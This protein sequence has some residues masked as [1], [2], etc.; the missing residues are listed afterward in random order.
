MNQDVYQ[1]VWL[2]FM[3]FFKLNVYVRGIEV[4]AGKLM[5]NIVVNWIR[6]MTCF[7]WNVSIYDV[8]RKI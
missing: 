4:D 1:Y 6:F 5:Q 2:Q 7:G 3:I 8:L